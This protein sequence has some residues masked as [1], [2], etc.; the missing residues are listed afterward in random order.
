M[1]RSNPNNKQT[2]KHKFEP[3]NP[4]VDPFHD[5][6]YYFFQELN[7]VREVWDDATSESFRHEVTEYSRNITKEYVL[8]VLDLYNKYTAILEEAEKLKSPTAG[9]G[10]WLSLLDLKVIAER[11]VSRLF[12]NR[13]DHR[14]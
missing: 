14:L 8:G 9:F 1:A 12:F 10:G 4:L 11:G 5:S 3:I 13:D 6:T 2:N 7:K